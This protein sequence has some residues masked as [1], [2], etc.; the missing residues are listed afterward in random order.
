MEKLAKDLQNEFP[1]IGGFSAS[2]L[3]RM[4]LFHDTYANDGKLDESQTFTH[5]KTL[6]IDSKTILIP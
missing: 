2:S 6:V 4:K 3:W 5:T 1:G